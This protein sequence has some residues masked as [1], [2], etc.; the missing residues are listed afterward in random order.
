MEQGKENLEDLAG[1]A[2]LTVDEVRVFKCLRNARNLY[3][4]LPDDQGKDL[5][6]WDAQRSTSLLSLGV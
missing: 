1:R 2:G 6:D 4:A 5:E 3:H